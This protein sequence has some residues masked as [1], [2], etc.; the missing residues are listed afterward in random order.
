[1]KKA[2]KKLLIS[3]MILVVAVSLAATSTFA[4]FTMN[5]EPQVEGFD[6]NVTTLDGL[7]ISL[8]PEGAADP[9]ATA[10]GQPG[11]FKSY[12]TADEVLAAIKAYNSGVF[13]E[14]GSGV[15]LLDLT[16]ATTADGATFSQND[17]ATTSDDTTTHYTFRLYFYSNSNYKVQLNVTD[18]YE[19]GV[20]Q[21]SIV[22]SE[23][24]PDQL[25][26]KA[27]KEIA[28]NTGTSGFYAH[29]LGDATDDNNIAIGTDIVAAAKDAARISF[30]DGTTVN[31]WDPNPTTGYTDNIEG[32]IAWD[33]YKFVSN[34]AETVFTIA[35]TNSLIFTGTPLTQSTDL[36]TLTEEGNG[37]NGY[38]DISIWLEGW[39]ANC[40]N[41]ILK[42]K[43]TIAL[44]FIGENI[45]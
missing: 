13:T 3:A 9:S 1:M 38:L 8:S 12:V 28:L 33:Y 4:W 34:E 36:V 16:H 27:W 14:G 45:I 42:D 35:Q 43:L 26:I 15:N 2:T 19:E 25:P 18:V 37:Y 39:D 6:V 5:N 20:Q 11:T 23:A 30:N 29:E 7:Y 10:K 44:Q 17:F 24:A 41:S 22:S 32:N 31:F 21:G 40:F